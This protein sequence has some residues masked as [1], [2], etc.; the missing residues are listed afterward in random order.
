MYQYTYKNDGHFNIQ[1]ILKDRETF[2]HKNDWI[3]N[4]TEYSSCD[5]NTCSYDFPNRTNTKR[6]NQV[7]TFF[8]KYTQVCIK[9]NSEPQF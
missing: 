2:Y 5:K 9:M 4:V 1:S 8:F 3:I 6:R 7:L